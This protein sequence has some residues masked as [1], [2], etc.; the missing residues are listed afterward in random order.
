M[1]LN[2]FFDKIFFINLEKRKDRYEECLVEFKK[3]GITAEKISA[4]D[5][6]K[7]FTAGLNRNAG[8]HGLHLTTIQILE[9]SIKN[10]YKNILILED[11][12]MFIDNLNTIFSQ[13][14]KSLPDD[15]D[16][17][18][19]GGS[20]MFNKGK[21]KCV[22]RIVDFEI[23][24]ETYKTLD[25]ELCTTTWTQTTH[26]VGINGKNLESLLKIFKEKRNPIDM[27]YAE[28]Q[29]N[30]SKTFTFLPSIALQR[31]S[32]SDIENV[33]VDYNTNKR[34]NF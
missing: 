24:A 9:T 6:S 22:S 25:Y 15:W 3:H 18:Y 7:T 11:D 34:W 10:S 30:G 14:I 33:V 2:S 28:L 16:L 8:A 5:G 23:N 32:F 31:P 27:I 21:F 29:Q 17:L 1:T 26:A 13:K 19:L 4:I 12:I 20:H